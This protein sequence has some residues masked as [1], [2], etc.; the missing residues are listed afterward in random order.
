MDS[1]QRH[2]YAQ[3]F[4]LAY[5]TKRGTEFQDW[6]VQIAGLAY[7]ADFDPIR[8][9]GPLGDFKCDGRR[10]ST[11][12]IFQCYA[13]GEIKEAET[14]AKINQDLPGAIQHWQGFI[15]AWCFVYNDARGVPPTVAQ[16]LDVVQ[17]QHPTVA[18]DRWGKAPLR[19]L[20]FSIDADQ[21]VHVFGYAPTLAMLSHVGF[22]ELKP[23]LEA[24]A[25]KQPDPLD[26]PTK[27]PSPSKITKNNLSSATSGLLQIGRLKEPVVEDFLALSSWPETANRIA[28]AIRDHYKGLVAIGMPAEEIFARLRIFIGMSAEPQRE[29]AELAVLSY[30]FHRC[31][32][33]E[34]PDETESQELPS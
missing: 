5:A 25:Q 4:E 23:V 11:G 16:H 34:D 9:Y 2:W 18:I 32:I 28:K 29:A 15:K 1:L 13:P 33:F 31:D 27:P 22:A 10:L 21:L 17:R 3:A 8:S 30:F 12:T 20:V 7:G 19:D 14:T 24:I 26:E 6:F